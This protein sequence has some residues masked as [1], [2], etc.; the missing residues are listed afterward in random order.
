MSSHP[1]NEPILGFTPGSPERVALQSELDR[2]MA[3]VVEIPCIINGEEGWT[4]NVVDNGLVSFNFY[5]RYKC[6]YFFH[7]YSHCWLNCK[8]F[9]AIYSKI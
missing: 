5:L 9:G 7:I 2:Q 8:L 6:F 1:V 4:N 3:E